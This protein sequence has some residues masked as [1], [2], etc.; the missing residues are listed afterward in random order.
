M[1]SNSDQP[2]VPRAEPEIIPP[3]R[4]RPQDRPQDWPPQNR[5]WPPRGFTEM[6]GAHRI[7][8]GRIGPFGFALMMLVAG[9]FA[10][11]LLLL[12]IGTALI[13]IPVLAAVI[14]IAAISGLLRRL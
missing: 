1:A 5:G 14:V 10:V 12:L 2:E 8:V 11:V 9:L 3:D 7:Y 6:H 4:N 13:W